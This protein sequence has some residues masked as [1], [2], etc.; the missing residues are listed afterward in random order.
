MVNTLSSIPIEFINPMDIL[1]TVAFILLFNIILKLK[2]KVK[3]HSDTLERAP[4]EWKV[5]KGL[6]TRIPTVS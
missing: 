2:I 4:R 6:K 3:Y 5:S 1:S